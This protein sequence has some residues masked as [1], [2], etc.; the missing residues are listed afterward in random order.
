MSGMLQGG[1]TSGS[2]TILFRNLLDSASITPD[3]LLKVLSHPVDVD[4]VES[5]LLKKRQAFHAPVKSLNRACVL[6]SYSFSAPA[7]CSILSGRTARTCSLPALVHQNC[8]HTCSSE[9][10]IWAASAS[11]PP[12]AQQLMYSLV[13]VC[14][15]SLA[16][17]AH[18]LCSFFK[19]Q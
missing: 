2:A 13:Y 15:P 8:I 7:C 5:Y 11:G 19:L 3:G 12:L 6:A 18:G 9:S 10:V 4:W 16:M 17:L 14:A 1:G